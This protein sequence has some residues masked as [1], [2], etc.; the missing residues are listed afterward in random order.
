[1]SNIYNLEPQAHGLI[2]F[3]TNFGDLDIE[4]FTQQCPKNTRN[5][6][7]LCLDGYYEGS[8]FDRVEKDFIAIGGEHD[9]PE[10]ESIETDIAPDEFHQ[11]LRFSRRGL[12]ATANTEKN[13][14]GPKIFFTLGPA[15]ELQNKHTIFG[16]LRGD[17]VYYLVDLNDCPVDEDMHP[18][19]EKKIIQVIVIQNP[20]PELKVRPHIKE[21]LR[22][23]QTNYPDC[24]P[25]DTDYLEPKFDI[26]QSKKLSFYEDSDDDEE[27]TPA[28]DGSKTEFKVPQVT[29]VKNDCSHGDEIKTENASEASRSDS[30][31]SESDE[32]AKGESQDAREKK[33]REIRENFKKLKQKLE[34]ESATKIRTLSDRRRES[35]GHGS[36]L[37]V[38]QESKANSSKHSS[39]E[40]PDRTSSG[41]ELRLATKKGRQRE[42]ETIELMQQFKKKLKNAS[43]EPN[44][45][46]EASFRINSRD[47]TQSIDDEET[48][49]ALDL[50]DGDDWL[51]HKFEAINT[52]SNSLAKDANTKGDDWYSIDDPRDPIVERVELERA[53]DH[54]RH[55]GR[56]RYRDDRYHD[57]EKGH[58]SEHRS[59]SRHR[60][61]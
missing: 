45:H 51:H 11:R 48:E 21:K 55:K 26:K 20:Y 32:K 24:T 4:L 38:T 54:G 61:R 3:K 41:Q 17:S 53:R 1:M 15:P 27:E 8:I 19:S 25:T 7:Q 49:L 43:S 18:I 6:V 56:D 50:V 33:L 47:E 60:H 34:N 52:T 5:F 39:I 16:R 13:A 9:T 30:K 57:R 58:R 29:L 31:D 46:K 12:L 10:A 35:L 37:N 23:L 36:P 44:N 59:S 40:D 2:T 22:K 28:E 14:N 42:R